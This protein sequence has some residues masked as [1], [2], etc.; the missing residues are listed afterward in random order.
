[1]VSQYIEKKSSNGPTIGIRVIIGYGARVTARP[2]K[3]IPLIVAKRLKDQLIIKNTGNTQ[4]K[5][6]SCV[7]NVKGKEVEVPLPAYTLYA[8][9]SIK[10]KLNHTLPVKLEVL[11]MD[12]RLGTFR[13]G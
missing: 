11:V 5:I 2:K 3:I 6:A 10:Q 13:T 12:K 8:G 7:Q 1:V 4:L 9:N